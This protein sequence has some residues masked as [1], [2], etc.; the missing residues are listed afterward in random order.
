M[1]PLIYN[2]KKSFSTGI[3]PER[4]KY[5][6]IKTSNM[7][8]D[9]TEPSNYRPLS[10]LSSCSK[11]LEKA[12]YLRLV[13]HINIYNKIIRQKFGFRKILATEDAIFNLTHEVLNAFISKIL[14]AS[15]FYDLEKALIM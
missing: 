6:V 5:S 8:G 10:M 11:P 2:F 3:F 13:E 12:L 4:L 15:I 9:N 7:K 1:P 14:V